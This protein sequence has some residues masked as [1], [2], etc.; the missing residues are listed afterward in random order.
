M[1]RYRRVWG[2]ALIALTGA[3]ALSGCYYDPYTGYYYAYPAYYPY[4]WGYP[5]AGRYPYPSAYP[6]PQPPTATPGL[7]PSPPPG[8]APSETPPPG[9]APVQ[10]TPLPLTPQ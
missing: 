2:A 8:T 5:Y 6:Y 3:G 9:N 7:P 4:P 1:T 10:R